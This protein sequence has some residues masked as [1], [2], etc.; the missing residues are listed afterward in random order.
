MVRRKV[1]VVK[2]V[3]Q[4]CVDRQKTEE[5]YNTL[6]QIHPDT[7]ISNK[8]SDAQRKSVAREMEEL[9]HLI[10]T[11]MN[12]EEIALQA[13][14]AIKYLEEPPLV[15]YVLSAFAVVSDLCSKGCHLA[16]EILEP[17]IDEQNLLAFKVFMCVVNLI[18]EELDPEW[19]S[20]ALKQCSTFLHQYSS[21]DNLFD[22]ILAMIHHQDI[23]MRRA[24]AFLF[25]VYRDHADEFI[26]DPDW[27]TLGPLFN[28]P[29]LLV[30]LLIWTGELEH[31]YGESPV[32]LKERNSLACQLFSTS[33]QILRTV[34]LETIS[35]C[36]REDDRD[37]DHHPS[38]KACFWILRL[39][40]EPEKL[41]MEDIRFMC[42]AYD[43]TVGHAD[44]DSEKSI[45]M[46]NSILPKLEHLLKL[47][48]VSVLLN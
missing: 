39:F 12:E 22:I 34:Y 35:T 15:P 11:S 4:H 19:K 2:E 42:I 46:I 17:I 25:N 20:D 28:D 9:K 48:L 26:I 30:R 44:I 47:S 31:E 6:K 40:G 37:Y 33:P 18:P 29:D 27:D 21:I 10:R 43:D 1:L 7:G 16:H 41:T 5:I 23:K 14:Q 36:S 13:K 32:C 3:K 38:S 8:V 24:A 45:K